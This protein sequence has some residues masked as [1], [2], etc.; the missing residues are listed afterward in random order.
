MQKSLLQNFKAVLID[1][2]VQLL[3]AI[4]MVAI[5]NG[6]LVLNPLIFRQAVMAMEGSET[7]LYLGPFHNRLW[8]W[9]VLILSVAGVSALFKYWMRVAFISISRDVERR[10]RSKI[11]G[12]IQAQSMRFFDKHGV[13][14]LISRL[15]NDISTYREVMG[16]GIIYPLYAVTMMIPGFIALFSLSPQMGAVALLPLFVVPITNILIRKPIYRSS[17]AVQQMLGEMSNLTQEHYS[18]IRMIKGYGAE[19][20]TFQQ[21]CAMGRDFLRD[22]FN[23]ASLQGLI[24]PFFS[25]IAKIVTVLLVLFAGL[26]I[27]GGYATLSTADF[28][29]F[30]WI[31]SYIFFPVLSIGWVVPIYQRGRAAY[32][33]LVEIYDEPIEVEDSAKEEIHIP[34]GADITFKGLS[35]TYPGAEVSSLNNLNLTIEGG[36]FVG[37]TGPV[38]AGKSTLFRL[39]NREYEI[40]KGTIFIGGRDIR[41][42]PLEAFQKAMVTVE[43]LPFLFSKSIRENVGF[44]NI[45]APQEEIERVASFADL[46]ETVLE[47]P[48]QYETIVGER[49]MTLSG[50]QKQRV[51][52]ARAFLVNRS[53]LLLDDIFS[54]VD[55]ATEKR[56]FEAMQKNF[57]G[58]MVLLISH[59]VSVLNTMDR[60]IYMRDGSVI[61]DGSPQTL[62]EN[63]GQYAALVAL[64]GDSHES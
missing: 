46:H 18:G 16:P 55:T 62:I 23:L 63:R 31:Q 1:Y 59:R 30:M 28:V 57:S 51:A 4:G 15:T 12:R 50:G 20:G 61:E 37:I 11:F 22:S 38:G 19:R 60:V 45:L 53:I 35:F 49:G 43:Q 17:M 33:R 40:P 47:F 5:S 48:E 9:V 2:R 26:T 21:F 3:K 14:E 39:L 58:K 6:L 42:Y 13:G 10:L 34:E 7:Q 25:L 36:T 29:S 27:I 44:G 52:M 8:A 32:D 41:E 24:F 56:I 64:Q 54:A